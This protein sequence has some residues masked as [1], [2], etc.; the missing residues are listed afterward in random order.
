M[1]NAQKLELDGAAIIQNIKERLK[2]KVLLIPSDGRVEPRGELLNFFVYFLSGLSINGVSKLLNAKRVK[3]DKIGAAANQQGNVEMASI[4]NAAVGT[5]KAS[6]SI[7]DAAPVNQ[8]QKAVEVCRE[9]SEDSNDD[10]YKGKKPRVTWKLAAFCSNPLCIDTSQEPDLLSSY[11]LQNKSL[12]EG[13]DSSEAAPGRDSSEAAAVVGGDLYSGRAAAA[14][15]ALVGPSGGGDV[16]L[17]RSQRWREK[18]PNRY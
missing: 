1:T 18:E 2:L 15:A 3:E 4:S 10:H 17:R 16:G 9:R 7:K 6:S 13:R 11:A 8:K 5:N 14:P 12:L